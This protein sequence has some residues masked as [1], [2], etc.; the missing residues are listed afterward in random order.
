[1]SACIFP[2]TVP[3]DA[4]LFPLVQ[5]FSPIVYCR[6][7]EDDEIPEVLQS[8]LARD[9]EEAGLGTIHVPSPLGEQRERFLA[10]IKDLKNRGDDYAARLKNISLSGIGRGG[11]SRRESKNAII[12]N[13]LQSKGVQDEV[14]EKQDML[15]WQARLLLKLGEIFDAE[16]L[17]LKRDLEKISEMENGLFS[18]LRKEHGQ[19][20]SLTKNIRSATGRTDGLQ[21][22][23]LKAWTRLY[24]LGD[25]RPAVPP[26]CFISTNQDAVDL[27]VEEY[28]RLD[29]RTGQCFLKLL[30][31][32][33]ENKP[34]PPERLQ[35][36][37]EHELFDRLQALLADPMA[38]QQE[39]VD[40]FADDTGAWAE[41]LETI[42]PAA[43]Y[44]RCRLHLYVLPKV[45]PCKLLME[46]FGR[47]EDQQQ[48]RPQKEA[49][50]T[51]IGWLESF[52]R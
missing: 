15:L 20:F 45:Q 34:L 4:I 40:V 51:V 49:G 30:L 36:L 14:R 46:A 43:E 44:G 6:A 39:Q 11:R 48:V 27:L 28:E 12:E 37:Q 26:N 33:G 32:S 7:V 2:E 50:D 5:V 38:G 21:G 1:M 47:D 23:R 16:Q 17:C 25:D 19:P 18:E 29:A 3:G 41:L 52:E 10:L 42:Y 22:L 31:P 8:P 9:L 35:A 24:C 13:L